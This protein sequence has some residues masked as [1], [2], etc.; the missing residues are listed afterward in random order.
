MNILSTITLRQ[1]L[2]LL[3]AVCILFSSFALA[4]PKA[5]A[6]TTLWGSGTER[7]EYI[8]SLIQSIKELSL[9]IERLQGSTSPTPD[10]IL[11]PPVIDPP[12]CEPFTHSL[13]PGVT[14]ATTNGEVSRLQTFL[15]SAGDF[16]YG[17]VT[18]YYGLNTQTAVQRWQARNNIVSSGSAESTG[19]GLVGALTRESLGSYCTG[20]PKI[21]LIPGIDPPEPPEPPEPDKP[22]VDLKINGQDGPLQLTP[23][24]AEFTWAVNNTVYDRCIAIGDSTEWTGQKPAGGSETVMIEGSEGDVI[25]YT[26]SCYSSTGRVQAVADTVKVTILSNDEAPCYYAPFDYNDDGVISMED[27][28]FLG[29]IILGVE[30]CPDGKDCDPNDSGTTNVN[31]LA[32]LLEIINGT[33]ACPVDCYR[34][35]FD[36]NDDEVID[37]K[38]IDFIQQVI[39]EFETCPDGKNC[40]PNGDGETNVFDYF[41][42]WEIINGESKLCS[43]NTVSNF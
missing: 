38:D 42:L 43:V 31:D 17:T 13:Y 39:L 32:R 21:V 33:R 14:D 19:Y 6:Q 30:I 23:G 24:S 10:A 16:T 11:P 25:L 29:D 36:Y 8:N 27:L 34:E 35:E 1:I 4:V 28:D 7:R 40:D 12:I 41:P 18:G 37:Q 26:I 2:F 15:K 3:A 5:E 9:E 22:I 20:G